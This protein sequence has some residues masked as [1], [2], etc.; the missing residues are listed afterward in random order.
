V[1][2]RSHRSRLRLLLTHPCSCLC[3]ISRLR[4]PSAS[5]D[6]QIFPRHRHNTRCGRSADR[7]DDMVAE[8]RRALGDSSGS[9]RPQRGTVHGTHRVSTTIESRQI[10]LH[11][12]E[13]MQHGHDGA[14]HSPGQLG[15]VGKR[16]Q[17][18]DSN[19]SLCT[20]VESSLQCMTLI[21]LYSTFKFVCLPL[22]F[23][24]LHLCEC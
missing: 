3:S 8:G 5:G 2:V 6:L 21:I 15:T 24:C 12:N 22:V 1:H 4:I 10:N 7:S 19:A 17:W 11:A 18:S 9:E 14:A 16:E 13:C 20:S 23:V